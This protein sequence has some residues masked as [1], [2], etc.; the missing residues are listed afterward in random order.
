MKWSFKPF[1]LS[2]LA[3]FL[4][5]PTAKAAP[6][7]SIVVNGT[8]VQTDVT[9]YIQQGT[10]FVPL[11]SLEHIQGISIKSWNNN[12]K[13]L[14]IADPS[15]S[16]TMRIEGT[17]PNEPQI[18]NGRVMVPI[19]FIAESFNCDVTWNPH[20]RTVYVAK[21]DEQTKTNLKSDNLTQ[22]R[23]AAITIPRLS[24]LKELSPG[25]SSTGNFR[26]LF[27]EG[28]SNSFYT[29]EDGIVNYYEII[30][31]AAW[32]LWSGK[33]GGT[34]NGIWLIPDSGISDET[35]QRPKTDSRVYFYNISSHSGQAQYG[36]ISTDGKETILGSGELDKLNDLFPIPGEN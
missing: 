32:R 34:R 22:A 1:L 11:R 26:L 35:G 5:V 10:T 17:R 20:T 3:L 28:K 13:T 23:A 30:G 12:T 6:A 25:Q 29:V 14:V 33:L 31:N 36:Y 2:C 15:Q 8:A 21:I 24:T 27:P 16:L 9:P 19:R 4:I 7:I 18:K